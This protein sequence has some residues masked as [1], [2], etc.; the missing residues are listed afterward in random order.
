[1]T[2][3][4]VWTLL[5]TAAAF[6]VVTWLVVRLVYSSLPPLPWTMVPALVIAAGAEA[7][8]GRGVRAR[9]LGRPG[10]K[11]PLPLYVAR[12]VALAKAS[13]LT[14]AVVG[15]VA[16]GFAAGAAGSLPSSVPRHDVITAG[17][18]LGASVLLALAALYLEHCCR[19]PGDPDRGQYV[20]PPRPADHFH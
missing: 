18:T 11:P 6:A 7:L 20:P 4:R 10:T 15:G 5:V 9:I 2:P 19:V 17:A 14:A 16:A 3:T 13:S 12:L 8:T 1:M